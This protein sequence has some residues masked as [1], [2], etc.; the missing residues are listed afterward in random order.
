VTGRRAF[1]WA[2]LAGT[3]G[4]GVMAGHWLSYDVAIPG[5]GLRSEILAAT[6]HSWWEFGLKAMALLAVVGLGALI[7]SRMTSRP[8]AVGV[9]RWSFVATR[10]IPLQLVAFLGMEAAE[11]LAV[12]APLGGLLD[13]HVLLIGLA[14]Q[15]IT[16]VA[17]AVLLT[18][19]DRAVVR[20][21]AAIH[22]R[23]S[24]APSRPRSIAL[25]YPV[26]VPTAR[27]LAGA[28]GLRGPPRS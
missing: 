13:H 17:G 14:F 11:R 10:L 16:A 24:V 1:R 27:R 3:A 18:W 4:I 2:P 6:G 28:V 25:P 12:G 7:A 23:R 21:A 8:D 26:L 20:V 19:F 15:V 5:A 22:S 9:D